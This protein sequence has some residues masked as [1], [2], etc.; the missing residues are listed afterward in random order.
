MIMQLN[1]YLFLTLLFFYGAYLNAQGYQA[2]HGSPYAGSSAIFNNPAAS[3]HS[4][5]QWELTLFATQLKMSSNSLY[6]NNFSFQNNSAATLS[7]KEGM[8]SRFFHMNFDMNLLNAF[9]KFNKS[10]VSFAMR[11]RTY[12]HIKTMPLYYAD[13]IHS[14]NNFLINNIHTPYVEGFVTH[15]GWLEA[16]LNYSQ[17]LHENNYSKLSG[18]ITLQIMKGIS[19]AFMKLNKLS[20]LASKNSSDTSFTFTNGSGLLGYSSNYDTDPGPSS[21]KEFLKKSLTRFGLSLGIEYLIYTNEASENTAENYNWKI[22]VSLMD[23]GSNTFLPSDNSLEF[24]NP[25]ST[26]VDNSVDNKLSS[27][28][29]MKAFKDSLKTIF[30]TSANITDNFSIS[31]PTRLIIN[32]DKN[33]SNHFFL[34][35]ELSMNFFSTATYAKLH[36]RE[37]NLLT[38]T[39]RWETF[40]WG[41]Y[42]PIQYNTQGQLW[43]GAALKLGP[44]V[45]GFHNLGLLKKNPTLNGGGYLLLSIHPFRKRNVLSKVDCSQ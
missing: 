32:F 39:P 3:V 34:N 29:T 37:L 36:T 19:G 8:A 12:N 25:A 24:Y 44:L 23:I 22:G 27:A 13:S 30:N 6:L 11:A 4:A 1:R 31:N 14:F 28:K 18:G 26:I 16:D 41:A 15:S 35:G 43:V 33:L 2:M 9:Y 10:A 21:L 17:L 40:G 45:L 7:L 38:I 5:Y 20:Y 42:L